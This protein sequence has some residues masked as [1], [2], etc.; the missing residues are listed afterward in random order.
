MADLDPHNPYR[1]PDALVADV[2]PERTAAGNVPGGH[3][4]QWIVDGFA[5]F[6]QQPG[7]WI[8]IT[9]VWMLIVVGLQIIPFI[10]WLAV[11]LLMPILVGGIMLGA[12]AQDRGEGLSF[13]HLFAGFSTNTGNLVVVGVLGLLAFVA[14]FAL[15]AMV[16]GASMFAVF[17]L[18]AANA[19]VLSPAIFT[20][21][22]GALVALALLIPVYMALWFAPALVAFRGVTATEAMKASFTANLKNIM[23]FLVYGLA[24]FVLAILASIPLALGWLVLGPTLIASVY[25]AYKDIFVE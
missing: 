2:V 19:T 14:I 1:A 22:F 11:N 23:P 15:V 21:L 5:L 18:G 12:R 10:G 24:M 16:F 4:W 25:T 7:M 17:G 6:K 9:L 8:G 20:A 3:G 13:G